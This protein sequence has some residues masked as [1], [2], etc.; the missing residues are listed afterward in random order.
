VFGGGFATTGGTTTID[1]D[2]W[3]ATDYRTM[4]YFAQV[5][6]N[7]NVGDFQATQFM[8]I[9]NGTDVFKSEYN[10]MYTNG[11]LG[12]FDAVS[13]GT[14]VTVT[15]TADAATSKTVKVVRTGITL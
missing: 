15:F 12:S 10:I 8:L 2:S 13:D 5:T 1:V 3:A 7:T 6:D 4:H 11:V 9:Q 14:T